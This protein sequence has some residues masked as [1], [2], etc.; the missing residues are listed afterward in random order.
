MRFEKYC[1]CDAGEAFVEPHETGTV[2][3]AF[4]SRCAKL[5]ALDRS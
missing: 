3:P 4:M 5:K 2:D 1:P